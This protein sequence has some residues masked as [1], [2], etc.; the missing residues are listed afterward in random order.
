MYLPVQQSFEQ[1][2]ELERTDTRVLGT[3]NPAH[4]LSQGMNR[5][6][7]HTKP[8]TLAG[9]SISLISLPSIPD[10]QALHLAFTA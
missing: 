6:V 5:P 8:M 1:E 3:R 9:Q 4:L 2:F 10:L 7:A